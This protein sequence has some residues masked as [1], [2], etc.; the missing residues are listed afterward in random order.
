MA[1][2]DGVRVKKRYGQHF[3]R[4]EAVA[5]SAVR[6]ARLGDGDN[7]L[8]IG[9]GDGFLTAHILE[10]PV[11][12]LWVYEIDPEWVAYVRARFSDERLRVLE[13]NVLDAD[14]SELTQHGTWKL[15]ANL[16]YQ[17]TFPILYLIQKNRKIITS[18]VIMIQEEVAQKILKTGGRGYGYP[19]L[20]FQHFFEW[21]L[22]DRVPPTSFLPPPKVNSRLLRFGARENPV[23]IP[24]EQEFWCFVKVL[25][26]QPRRTIRNNIQQ[27]HY[28]IDAFDDATL[29]LR[30][31]QL[32]MADILK[33]WE[34]VIAAS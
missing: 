18:G 30:A 17:I 34:T 4:D 6:N 11:D 12:R 31:Q 9:C 8:E 20:F 21:E 27:T 15:V 7:V 19:S 29:R 3:L 23:T 32:R 1:V 25:F 2:V 24:R 13:E 16:P 14:L 28:P 10:I 22:L 26:L 5:R 33:L